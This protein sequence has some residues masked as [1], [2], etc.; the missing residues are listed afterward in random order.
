MKDDVIGTCDHC[1]CEILAGQ[2]YIDIDG[3]M[4][5]QDCVYDFTYAEWMEFTKIKWTVSHVPHSEVMR[6]AME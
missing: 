1:G 4:V 2:E 6:E 5:C 3:W